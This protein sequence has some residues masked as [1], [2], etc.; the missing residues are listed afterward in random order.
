MVRRTVVSAVPAAHSSVG[1]KPATLAAAIVEHCLHP[2]ALIS[3][4]D[5]DYA[6]QIVKVLHLLGTP[7]FPT[8]HTYDKVRL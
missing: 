6:A 2:R 1:P 7:G 4:M 5:A 3:P 8:F